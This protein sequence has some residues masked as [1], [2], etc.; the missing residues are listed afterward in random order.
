[1]L[2]GHEACE[3]FAQLAEYWST[4]LDAQ[5]WGNFLFVLIDRQQ[6]KPALAPKL[7]MRLSSNCWQISMD[8]LRNAGK[9][10]EIITEIRR[11]IH[12]GYILVQCV[13]T[14]A[15]DSAEP[16]H[17]INWLK[18]LQEDFVAGT[19]QIITYLMLRDFQGSGARQKAFGKAF[20]ASKEFFPYLYLLSDCA[21][22]Q[23]AVPEFSIWRALY[24]ELLANHSVLRV[25]AGGSLYSLG[26]S[27]LN[28]NNGELN[29]LRRH[30]AGRWFLEQALQDMKHTDVWKILTG[31]EFSFPGME[32]HELRSALRNWLDSA[33]GQ[34]A[35][36]PDAAERKNNRILTGLY[37]KSPEKAQAHIKHFYQLNGG[38]MEAAKAAAEQFAL[39]YRK[40]I[41]LKLRRTVNVPGFLPQLLERVT[42]ELIALSGEK[43]EPLIP[44]WV[45]RRFLLPRSRRK[46]FDQ[47]LGA[48]E[49]AYERALRSRQTALYAKAVADVLAGIHSFI[50]EASGL[51]A[52]LSK[53]LLPDHV[54][55][56]F[57]GKY[58]KYVG[59]VQDIILRR[60]DHS[61]L[62]GPG[63]SFYDEAGAPVIAAFQAAIQS[64]AEKLREYLP[65]E[66][67]GKFCQTVY[68]EYGTQERLHDF[69]N[70]YLSQSKRMFFEPADAPD[71]PHPLYYTDKGL[72][73]HPWFQNKTVIEAENDNVER[74]DLFQLKNG[75]EWY[76]DNNRCFRPENEAPE[77]VSELKR[78]FGT[79]EARAYNAAEEKAESACGIRHDSLS[80]APE[81]PEHNLAI[82]IDGKRHVLIWDWD[83]SSP[84]ALVRI[85]QN[86]QVTATINCSSDR[87]YSPVG[88][89]PNGI[90]ITDGLPY[91][92]ITVEVIS[93]NRR[94]Y[95]RKQ[96]AGRRNRVT[97]RLECAKGDAA[98]SVQ[99]SSA[100]LSALALKAFRAGGGENAVLYPLSAAGGGPSHRFAGLKLGDLS[101]C[102]L[103]PSPEE[104]FP[105]VYT[106]CT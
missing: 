3:R 24:G 37:G 2:Y 6:E 29:G 99:C 104:Q 62:A 1:M 80:P 33:V 93:S 72:A 60:P 25:L 100:D 51:N 50:E 106:V 17:L 36:F 65:R 47:Y 87:F 39:E 40:S 30:L 14:M 22:D 23:S 18:S 27:T 7:E 12:D 102:S 85:S 42:T 91:G 81:A 19:A 45:N 20:A 101:R 57:A 38:S 67:A 90:D 11:R 98:L 15:D 43:Q 84:S 105:T 32:A 54:Y 71:N 53:E 63:E 86:G 95:A 10:A 49:K 66:C 94:L 103:I 48:V 4:I 96:M 68:W 77:S 8:A 88:S 76:L 69:L 97:Y 56:T 21:V 44:P 73:G 35:V 52:L 78:M 89:S 70:R 26:F 58:E 41:A 16:E 64:D 61:E 5:D 79:V 28:A 74:V 9:P 75:L 34:R 83:A 13:C 59:H 46:Y 82:H 92:G 55:E 31:D